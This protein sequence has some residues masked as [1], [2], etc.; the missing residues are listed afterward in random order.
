MRRLLLVRH[1][2]TAATRRRAFPQDEPIDD[3]EAVRAALCGALPEDCEAICS[4]ALRCR[5][6][7]SAAGLAPALEPQIAECDFG[8]WCGQT[9][10]A[11]HAAE[12][13]LAG[14]WMT[15]PRA[16]PHGGESLTAFFGRVSRWLDGEACRDGPI[17]AVT[18]AGV[19]KAS[20]VHALAAPV[21]AFWQVAVSPLS[22]TELH[23]HDGH[24]K[25]ERANWALR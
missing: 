19:V 5:Q 17:V 20:V 25:L 14:S 16:S 7:A 3:A 21:A 9:F 8:A 2:P 12:P 11:V 15:D 6:T 23:A 22:I 18:H 13:A 24:W 4:P 1:A 10:A